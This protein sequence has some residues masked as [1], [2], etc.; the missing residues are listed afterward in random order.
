MSL[1]TKP[2]SLQKESKRNYPYYNVKHENY[3][4]S[5]CHSYAYNQRKVQSPYLYGNMEAKHG[6]FK[7]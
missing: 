5:P 3:T 7:N 2:P 6:T 4:H 1:S